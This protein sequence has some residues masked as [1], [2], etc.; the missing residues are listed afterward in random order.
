MIKYHK[1]LGLL[2]WASCLLTT[3]CQQQPAKPSAEDL[4]RQEQED[5]LLSL[6]DP[7][8]LRLDEINSALLIYYSHFKKMPETLEALQS[9]ALTNRPLEFTCP[10]SG[11]VYVYAPTVLYGPGPER[12]LVLY[13]PVAC[14]KGRRWAVVA[15]PSRPAQ[16]VTTWVVPIDDPTFKLLQSLPSTPATPAPA[17]VLPPPPP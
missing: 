10:V 8:A 5:V 16:P 17:M 9:A 2:L 15:A 1:S 6:T 3:A 14:H 13:D 11:K 4:K 12:R 7:C